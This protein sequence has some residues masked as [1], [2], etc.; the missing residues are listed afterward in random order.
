MRGNLGRVFDRIEVWNERDSHPVVA[1]DSLVAGDDRAQLP[2][3]AA[4]KFDRGFGADAVKIEGIVP[5][6]V[7]GTE[8]AVRLLHEQRRLRATHDGKEG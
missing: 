2:R 3:L 8:E 7:D 4:A 6:W 1:A 5:G